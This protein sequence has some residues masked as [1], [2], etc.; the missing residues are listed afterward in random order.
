[1]E[2]TST[3]DIR[4]ASSI[5]EFGAVAAAGWPLLVSL[6]SMLLI[7]SSNHILSFIIEHP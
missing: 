4:M 6:S 5:R 3:A 2:T 7:F 1:M